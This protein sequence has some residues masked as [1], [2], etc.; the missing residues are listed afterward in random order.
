LNDDETIQAKGKIITIATAAIN[1][2]TA[3]LFQSD[4]D[5]VISFP[6]LLEVFLKSFLYFPLDERDEKNDHK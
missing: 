6:T 4:R 3:I 2:V 5:D 1:K